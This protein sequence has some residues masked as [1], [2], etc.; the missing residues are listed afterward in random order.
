M[1][2]SN[3]AGFLFELQGAKRKER[4]LHATRFQEYFLPTSPHIAQ[5]H[6]TSFA[7]FVNLDVAIAA[8]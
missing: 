7:M 4:V 6:P 3:D 5:L 8:L 2:T 1:W